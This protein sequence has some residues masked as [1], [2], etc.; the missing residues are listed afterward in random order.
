MLLVRSA[1][2]RRRE[3]STRTSGGEDWVKRPATVYMTA[4]GAKPPGRS[5]RG[6]L[7][8]TAVSWRSPA[9]TFAHES[10]INIPIWTGLRRSAWRPISRLSRGSWNRRDCRCP[11]T[12]H[13]E[14]MT[15][16]RPEV[17]CQ[18]GERCHKAG[19]RHGR[20]VRSERAYRL[21]TGPRSSRPSCRTHA[22]GGCHGTAGSGY[23]SSSIVVG[24]PPAGCSAASRSS[25]RR[26]RRLEHLRTHACRE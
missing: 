24:E 4:C 13:F 16:L 6:S 14:R 22:D 25:R 19:R 11:S 9:R 21:G 12:S 18:D 7:R 15:S 8:L 17:P 26:R 2:E 1:R 3:S 10:S 23:C 5:V 20:G